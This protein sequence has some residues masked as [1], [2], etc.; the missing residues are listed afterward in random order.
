MTLS[1]RDLDIKELLSMLSE[2]RE[3]NIIYEDDVRG[4]VSIDLHEVPFQ[5][6]L[7]AAVAMAG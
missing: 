4:S 5:E 3:M 6:A 1:A 2:S 7:R